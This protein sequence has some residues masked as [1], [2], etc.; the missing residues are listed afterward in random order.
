MPLVADEEPREV[1]WYEG[2]G[3]LPTLCKALSEMGISVPTEIQKESLPTAIT[4]ESVLLCAETG[5]G[6]TLSFLLPL[7]QRIKIDE[8]QHGIQ[9]RPHRPRALVLVP[10]R[11]LGQQI[12]QVAKG[13]SRHAKFSSCGLFGGA[14]MARQAERL[15]DGVDLVV[16]TPGRIVQLMKE[17]E[18]RVGDVRFVVADEADT[19]AAQGFGDDL[20]TILESVASAG[21]AARESHDRAAE[22]KSR[23]QA[24]LSG[25][26]GA[27]SDAAALEM[28]AQ[29]KQMRG[30]FSAADRGHVQCV[31]AAATVPGPVKE[32]VAST[33]PRFR[34]VKTTRAHMVPDRISQEFVRVTGSDRAQTLLD[35]IDRGQRM[36]QAA[37]SAPRPLD[38]AQRDATIIF[39]NTKDSAVFAAKLLRER[40]YEV[41][42]GHGWLAQTDRAVQLEAFMSGKSKILVSTDIMARGIDT[43]N[44]AHVVNFDF[45]RTPVD[46]LHRVGRTARSG[47]TGRVTN[48]VAKADYTLATAIERASK[49]GKPIETLTSRRADYVQGQPGLLKSDKPGAVPNEPYKKPKRQPRSGPKPAVPSKKKPKDTTMK[50]MSVLN[51]RKKK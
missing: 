29:I 49:L 26:D 35:V 30:P 10:T 20:K 43:I 45:P 24:H 28:Q 51:P 18:L 12:L 32:I 6:K 31:L 9:T 21:R 47:G 48:L 23:L 25:D 50:K 7:V 38:L 39:C 11:E 5:S 37:W 33:F 36:N 1:S 4:G 8:D 2:I 46:Y 13:L 44:V 19:M 3:L 16:G 34:E 42:E 40:G 41:S 17:G 22:M 27:N 14:S 15:H